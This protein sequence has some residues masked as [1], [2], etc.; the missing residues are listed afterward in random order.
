M[1]IKNIF[2]TLSAI[3]VNE[4]TEKKEGL[5][6]LSWAWAWSEFQKVCPNATYEIVKNENGLPYF[7]DDS[8]AIVYTRVTVGAITHE[9][10]LPVMDSKNKAMKKEPYTYQTRFGEKRVEAFTMFDV[11][12]AIMR[13]LVKN[14]AMFGL[15][16]YIY[17]GEDL[18]ET[19]QEEIKKQKAEAKQNQSKAKATESDSLQILSNENIDYAIANGIAEKTLK[20]IGVKYYASKEQKQKLENSLKK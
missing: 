12:K 11:N 13:C 5:T 10:W 1:E 19:E 9:M 6:Y 7:S 15:G 4:K 3:N 2:E 17:S 20:L 18:P 14:L 16:I 8:G